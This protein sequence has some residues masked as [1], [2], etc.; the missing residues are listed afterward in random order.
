[1]RS[2]NTKAKITTTRETAIPDAVITIGY[3][4]VPVEISS[5]EVAPTS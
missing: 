5:G 2:A 3:K 4:I 1:M